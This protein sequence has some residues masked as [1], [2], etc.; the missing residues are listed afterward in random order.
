MTSP[1]YKRGYAAGR[2]RVATDLVKEAQHNTHADKFNAA[3][4][5]VLPVCVQLNGWKSGGTL[6]N[7]VF[8]RVSLAED[9]ANEAVKNMK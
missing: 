4:L 1:D 2:K 7:G 3:F 9:F 8:Q 6:I 5:A